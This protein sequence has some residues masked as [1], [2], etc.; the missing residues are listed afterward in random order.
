M[1]GVS[2]TIDFSLDASLTGTSDLGS[3]KQRITVAEALELL[4]GTDAVNKANILFAD[5]RTLA[6]SA[7]EN[8]DLA[9]VL[10]NAFGAV[11]AAAEIVAIYIKAASGNTNTVNFG[12]GSSNGFTG[13]FADATDRLK[14]APG[15]YVALVSRAGWGVT[16]ATGDI[17]TVLN[18]GAGTGV[19][20]D[21]VILGRTVAA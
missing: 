8:L 9:G 14:I 4:P 6:A 17:L 20:Y 19:T 21:I 3:P 13:P 15:E 2:A 7:T 1:A 12:P 16:G 11:V 18:G 10:T 5:T